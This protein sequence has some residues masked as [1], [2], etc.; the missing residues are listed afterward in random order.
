MSAVA[1]TLA[2]GPPTDAERE[3]VWEEGMDR[4]ECDEAIYAARDNLDYEA[5]AEH[6]RGLFFLHGA[7][8]AHG[9]S[10]TAGCWIA[11]DDEAVPPLPGCVVM[12]N[13]R[14]EGA[15]LVAAAPHIVETLRA[16][17]DDLAATACAPDHVPPEWGDDAAA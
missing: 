2:Y 8:L 9:A 1:V 15:A 14:L 16:C 6:Q 17:A 13:T 7:L 3:S 11:V 12:V 5:Q 10:P 4:A